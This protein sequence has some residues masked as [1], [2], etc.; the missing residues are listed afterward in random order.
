MRESKQSR[1]APVIRRRR[2]S[3]GFP[4][5]ESHRVFEP[6]F[7]RRRGGTGLGLAI[8]RKNVEEHGGSI[9]AENRPAG[10][11]R[12]VVQLPADPAEPV[13]EARG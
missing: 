11:A 2:T 8:A 12:V 4:P 9:S 6:F 13:P 3:A 7:T 10:G 1:N 5:G